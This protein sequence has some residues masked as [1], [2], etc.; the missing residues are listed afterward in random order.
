[1]NKIQRK[2]KHSEKKTAKSNEMFKIEICFQILQ[3]H[4]NLTSLPAVVLKSNLARMTALDPMNG[5]HFPIR[6]ACVCVRVC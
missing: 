3:I 4:H 1:M 6:T 2:I 5:A